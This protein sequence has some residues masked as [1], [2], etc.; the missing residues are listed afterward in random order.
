MAMGS[1]TATGTGT[2][3]GAISVS[4]K[5]NF[6]RQHLVAARYFTKECAS[7]EKKDAV[8]EQ[9]KNEHRAC[10]TGA[11]IFSVAFVEASINEFYLEAVDSN[12]TSLSG[13]TVQQIAVL[14]EIWESVE[15]H[16][17]LGK[18][19]IALAVCGK[20]RFEKGASPFQGTDSLVK[21]RN[22]LIHYRPE[23]D[24][25]LKVHKELQDRL[26]GCF[27]PNRMTAPGN[28]W[29]PHQCL[30]AGCAEWAVK[31]AADFVTEFCTRLGIPCRVP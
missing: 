31:Q 11:V 16:S 1:L 4:V 19:Q 22:A 18:Y 24:T 3:T 29:F 30:G 10:V 25:E 12:Q 13:L 8:T 17:L 7:I 15:K 6:S 2:V 26:N 14:A 23:W 20:N 9:N 21:M 27:I 5:H 28:L